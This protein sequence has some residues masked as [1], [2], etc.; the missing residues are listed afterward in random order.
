M[1]LD[2]NFLS[3][4]SELLSP[5]MGTENVGPFLYSLVG[6][7]RPQKILEI[8][9]GYT[10]LFLLQALSDNVAVI[11]SERTAGA[12]DNDFRLSS[13]YQ[14]PYEP[15]LHS[16][17][18]SVHPESTASK[19]TAAAK[20]L[21]L[22]GLFN[23]HEADFQGYAARIPASDQ[24]FD[25]IWFDC[26]N[27]TYFQNFATE[28]FPRVNQNGGL[29]AMHSLATNMHGQL[30]MH[31]LKLK[32]STV[33]FHDFEILSL[34]EPHKIRQNSITMIRMTSRSQLTLHSVEP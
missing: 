24:P 20:K 33:N 29:V 16:I 32:Q 28:Y 19:V 8:G 12:T 7:I 27:L 15:V 6:M 2:K 34:P 22:D 23:L 30:F 13:F 25:L 4:A 10:S 26:G 18:N 3:A 9:A 14:R 5:A 21:N 31:A 17:D 1:M 11:D